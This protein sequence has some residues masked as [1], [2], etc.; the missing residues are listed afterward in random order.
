[1]SIVTSFDEVLFD[2]GIISAGGMGSPEFANTIIRNP[3]TGIYKVNINRFDPIEN[4]TVDLNLLSDAQREYTSRFWRGGYA[5]A[6]GFRARI[7]SDYKAAAEV[8]GTGNGSNHDFLLTKT[9]NRPGTAGHANVRRIIKPVSNTNTSAGSVTLYEPDGVTTRVIPSVPGGAAFQVFLNGV[10]QASG[11]TINN[12][13]GALHFTTAPSVGV[14]VSWAGEFDTPMR[15]LQNSFQQK[16][17]GVVSEIQGL[18]LVEIL[19]A[20]LGIT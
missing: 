4:W 11:W 10:N 5:S 9:Y 15:M 12:V 16:V 1:M 2:P 20:E 13:T 7:P 8:I 6:F 17:D 14:V 19:P 3:S 18:N